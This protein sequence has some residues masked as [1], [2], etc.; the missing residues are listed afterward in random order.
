[1]SARGVAVDHH[2]L[3]RAQPKEQARVPDLIDDLGDGH[4]RTEIVADH[5]DRH[6]V[7]IEPARAKAL[8]AI[9]YW[10][11]LGGAL[12]SRKLPPREVDIV[13]EELL[14]LARPRS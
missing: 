12:T 11:Y 7:G 10:T 2:A 1:M 13:V 14:A 9:F 8:A 3:A 6:A 5:R 4:L